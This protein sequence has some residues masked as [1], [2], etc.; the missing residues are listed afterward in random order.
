MPPASHFMPPAVMP[1]SSISQSFSSSL[2]RQERREE[3]HERQ[4]GKQEMDAREYKR[5]NSEQRGDN[6]CEF[7]T[8]STVFY[9]TEPSLPD[10]SLSAPL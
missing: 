3:R 5:G 10:N 9:C 1:A 8:Y 6:R 4:R 7:F 2:Q